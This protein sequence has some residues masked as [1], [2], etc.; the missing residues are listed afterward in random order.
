MG[1]KVETAKRPS[2][3]LSGWGK[4]IVNGQLSMINCQRGVMITNTLF[5]LKGM[6]R[7]EIVGNTEGAG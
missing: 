7:W 5:V 4:E 2:F 1:N 6:V 3:L